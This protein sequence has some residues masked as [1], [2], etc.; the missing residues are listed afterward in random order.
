MKKVSLLIVLTIALVGC[1]KDP[2]LRK[3]F[4]PIPTEREI[5]KPNI[6]IEQP[7]EAIPSEEFLFEENREILP[8]TEPTDPIH[9][10]KQQHPELFQ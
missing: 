5:P 6:V 4:P 10:M 2:Y 8:A 1:G 7:P 3:K 9:N